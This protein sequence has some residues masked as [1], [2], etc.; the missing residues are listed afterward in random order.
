MIFQVFGFIN[1][2]KLFNVPLQIKNNNELVQAFVT[3]NVSKKKKKHKTKGHI[4][5]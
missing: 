4:Y 1:W 2:F 5:F 3:F